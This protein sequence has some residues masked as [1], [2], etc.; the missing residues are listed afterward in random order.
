LAKTGQKQSKFHLALFQKYK[1]V[2][3]VEKSQKL[4]IWH[5]KAKLATLV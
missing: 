3:G 5:Q 4:E 1:K 2:N